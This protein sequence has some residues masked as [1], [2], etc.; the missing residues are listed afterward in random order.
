MKHHHTFEFKAHEISDA[1]GRKISRLEKLVPDARIKLTTQ[2][3]LSIEA[4][5][6]VRNHISVVEGNIHTYALQCDSYA[7]QKESKSY[8]LDLSDVEYF[9]MFEK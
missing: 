8:T 6:A 5:R 4:R 2:K 7:S 1:C 9:G 3:D